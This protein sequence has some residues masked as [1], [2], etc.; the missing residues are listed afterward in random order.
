MEGTVYLIPNRPLCISCS[1]NFNISSCSRELLSSVCR[2][3][4]VFSLVCSS[5]LLAGLPNGLLFFF[6]QRSGFLSELHTKLY[7]PRLIAW[8]YKLS[9]LLPI[10]VVLS[11][12]TFSILLM[13]VTDSVCDIFPG[14][15]TKAVAPRPQL[16]LTSSFLSVQ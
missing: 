12:F 13:A 9:I 7:S 5:N 6:F 2:G 1:R 3:N 10:R 4:P 14:H 11:E 16:L 15:C 8:Q